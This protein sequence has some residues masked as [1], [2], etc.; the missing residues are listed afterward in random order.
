MK[1]D[2][3]IGG[4]FLVSTEAAFLKT[5]EEIFD[6][7]W[8]KQEADIAQLQASDGTT[9]NITLPDGKCVCVCMYV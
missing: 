9:I 7:L 3:H 5:R 2:G 8:S 4:E 1:S 6:S